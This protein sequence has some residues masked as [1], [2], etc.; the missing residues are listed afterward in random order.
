MSRGGFGRFW[1][2][3]WE[4]EFFLVVYILYILEFIY[5]M[6]E[7]YWFFVLIM[8]GFGRDEGVILFVRL[9]DFILGCVI[10]R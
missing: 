6:G 3:F 8:C 9:V 1:V 10:E 2:G 7:E 4:D 5:R